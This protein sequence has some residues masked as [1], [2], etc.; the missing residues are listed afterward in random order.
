MKM[1]RPTEARKIIKP[2]V[3]TIS[4]ALSRFD[5]VTVAKGGARLGRRSSYEQGGWWWLFIPWVMEVMA[6]AAGACLCLSVS[7]AQK[8]ENRRGKMRS[9]HGRVA[10]VKVVGRAGPGVLGSNNGPLQVS[11]TYLVI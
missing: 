2:I 1:R 9:C 6:I 11:S 10:V 8:G 7:S 3:L 5:D 4:N